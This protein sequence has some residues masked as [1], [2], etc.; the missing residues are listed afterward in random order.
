M[1]QKTQAPSSMIKLLSF[2]LN[3]MFVSVY[4]NSKNG[5]EWNIDSGARRGGILSPI[6]YNFYFKCVI[7]RTRE[8]NTGCKLNAESYKVIGYSHDLALL[9]TSKTGLQLLIDD[10]SEFR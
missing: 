2:M 5:D 10:V 4:F 9:P 1:L 6:H 8:L 7:E 3:N